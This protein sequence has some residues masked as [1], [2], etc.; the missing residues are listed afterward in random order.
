[1]YDEVRKRRSPSACCLICESTY[2]AGARLAKW[3][4]AALERSRTPPPPRLAR[5][6]TC[7]RGHLSELV[8]RVPVSHLGLLVLL[9]PCSTYARGTVPARTIKCPWPVI[10]VLPTTLPRRTYN[11]WRFGRQEDI[12]RSGAKHVCN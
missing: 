7:G 4:R 10:A 2:E 11:T 6:T 12:S 8:P 9:F 3:D 1:M 5:I